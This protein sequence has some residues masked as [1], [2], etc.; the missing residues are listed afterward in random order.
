MDFPVAAVVG[1]GVDVGAGAGP[2]A[3]LLTLA[4]ASGICSGVAP[5]GD[6]QA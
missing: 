3:A 1:A 4:A 2:G 5:S 6:S